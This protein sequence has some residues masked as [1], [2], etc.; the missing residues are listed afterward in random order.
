MDRICPDVGKSASG[1]ARLGH[2]SGIVPAPGIRP[3]AACRAISGAA[4]SRHGIGFSAPCK[5]L[6]INPISLL[7]RA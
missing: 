1:R 5:S 6:E 3:R 4:E 2:F 7:F